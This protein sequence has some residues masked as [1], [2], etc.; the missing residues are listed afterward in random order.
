MRRVLTL[1]LAALL[2]FPLASGAADPAP[3]PPTAKEEAKPAKTPLAFAPKIELY[4]TDWCGYCRKARKFFTSRGLPFT[5]YNIEK[6]QE[7]YGRFRKMNPQG[8]VPLVLI[9]R[10]QIGGYSEQAYEKALSLAAGE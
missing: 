2:V 7:A 3:A 9:G 8:G 10:Y 5:D 4:G 1:A 6:D